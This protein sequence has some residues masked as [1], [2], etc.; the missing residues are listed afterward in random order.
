MKTSDIVLALDPGKDNFAW[1]FVRGDGTVLETGMLKNTLNSFKLIH[2]TRG[3]LEFRKEMW[4]LLTRHPI[5]VVVA[6]RYQ[7]RGSF[8]GKGESCE[9]VNLMLGMMIT[10]TRLLRLKPHIVLMP[11]SDWKNWLSFLMTGVRGGLEKTPD[12][13]GYTEVTKAKSDRKRNPFP[14][15]EHQFDAIGIGLYIVC[16]ETA[17]KDP[18]VVVRGPAKKSVDAI[19]SG[20]RRSESVSRT[21]CP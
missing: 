19:W 11:A 17:V 14:I 21:C 15:K 12:V 8:G 2:F 4:A 9:F 16:K 1:A 6:E 20:R 5:F 7:I 3:L 10:M 18:L 13:F